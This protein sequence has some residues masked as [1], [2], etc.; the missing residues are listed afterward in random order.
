MFG[1]KKAAAAADTEL[2]KIKIKT[3]E[4]LEIELKQIPKKNSF[5]YFRG[6]LDLAMFVDL[7]TADTYKKFNDAALEQGINND[8]LF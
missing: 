8:C 7:I 1:K 5:N 3:L 4:W 2:D 6:M